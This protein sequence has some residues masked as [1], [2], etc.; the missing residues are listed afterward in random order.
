MAIAPLMRLIPA[1]IAKTLSKIFKVATTSFFGRAPSRDSDKVALVGILSLSWLFVL[2]ALVF[3]SYAE[4]IVPFLPDDTAYHLAIAIALVV[5]GGPVVGLIIG[6][7][8]NRRETGGRLA[9]TAVQGYGYALAIG[10]LTLALVIVVPIVKSTHLLRNL[11]MQH[12]T[13]MIPEGSFDKVERKIEKVLTEQD[14]DVRP[15]KENP[16]MAAIL[17]SLVWVQAKIFRQPMSGKVRILRG[18]FK[19]SPL[20][21]ELHPTDITVR[22][23]NGIAIHVF[24]ALADNLDGDELYFTWDEDGQELEDQIRKGRKEAAQGNPPDDTEIQKI[25]MRLRTLGLDPDQ[26]STMRRITYRLEIDVLRARLRQAAERSDAL[27]HDTTSEQRGLRSR[28][29]T[30]RPQSPDRPPGLPHPR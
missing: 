16:L 1:A 28:S 9:L 10:T 18:S 23:R 14:I 3:P 17:R 19:D 30:D 29:T 6:R 4:L 8:T 26:W 7:T 21:I 5:I 24:A 13:I 25:T 22:A 20:T 15:E 12:M 11:E 27:P 2:P